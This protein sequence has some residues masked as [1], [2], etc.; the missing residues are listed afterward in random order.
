MLAPCDPSSFAPAGLW[1]VLAALLSGFAAE[2]R[3]V[4][5]CD[6]ILSEHISAMNVH[7]ISHLL[8]A[9]HSNFPIP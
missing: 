7:T 1:L 3:A 6:G 2:L 8:R 9:I 4:P 5:E